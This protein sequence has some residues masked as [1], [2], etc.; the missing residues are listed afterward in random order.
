MG[1][2]LEFARVK[3]TNLGGDVMAMWG[4]QGRAPEKA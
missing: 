2:Y 1:E 3:G 4:S